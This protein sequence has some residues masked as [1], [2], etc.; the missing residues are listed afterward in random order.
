MRTMEHRILLAEGSPALAEEIRRLLESARFRID[1]AASGWDGLRRAQRDPPGLLIADAR[2]PEMDGFA[3]CRAVRKAPATRHVP[4]ILMIDGRET[5]YGMAL[6]AGADD[7]ILQDATP[8]E[9]LAR[10]RSCLAR[11]GDGD[12]VRG[13]PPGSASPAWRPEELERLSSLL[14]EVL[15]APAGGRPKDPSAGDLAAISCPR[16]GS[17][18]HPRA[19]ALEAMLQDLRERCLVEDAPILIPDGYVLWPPSRRPCAN[20][21]KLSRRLLGPYPVRACARRGRAG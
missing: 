12:P 9:L 1:V 19:A 20:P 13:D 16:V 15:G 11:P 14:A 7:F 4:V 8:G 3:L 17:P 21:T 10:V 2:L 18:P 5:E 6:E